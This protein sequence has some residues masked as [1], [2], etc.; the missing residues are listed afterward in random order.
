[1]ALA[2]FYGVVSA[3]CFTLVGLW[4]SAVDRRRELLADPLSRRLVGGVY[5]SFL[6]PAVMG[7]FAEIEPGVSFIWR[8]T[9]GLASIVGAVS[10]LRLFAIDRDRND[11]TRGPFRR[12]RWVAAVLYAVVILLGV[13]PELAGLVGL[14][15]LQAAAMAVALLVVVAHGLAWELLTTKAAD[16]VE[17]GDKDDAPAGA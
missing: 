15:G 13:A 11:V 9:F 2:A 5:I 1:M 8:T 4:W 17:D 7:L 12:H 16:P 10:A 6:V 14:T 3:T